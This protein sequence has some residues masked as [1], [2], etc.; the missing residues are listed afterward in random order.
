MRI[1]MVRKS[2]IVVLGLMAVILGLFWLLNAR[3]WSAR[4]LARLLRIDNQPMVIR[5]PESFVPRLPAGFKVS[6]LARGFDQPRCVA[7]APNGDVFVADSAAGKI[8]VLHLPAN[9]R[10]VSAS[11]KIFAEN[12]N[13]PFGIAFHGE[14]VYVANTNQVIRFR[15]DLK[16]SNRLSDAEPI[17]NLPGGGYNQHWTRS[18]A[19]SPDGKKLFVSLGS[20]TNISVE[21]DPRRAAILIADPDGGNMQIYAGGLRNA[22]GIAFNPESGDLWASVNE[23]DDISDDIPSDFFTHVVEGGFYWWPYAYL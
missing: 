20:K 16:S 3:G 23:R 15:Y 19:F 22:V 14:Y 18:L 7:P 12:L 9:A 2:I 8:L 21:S 10:D 1:Q 11:S 4:I 6:I 17:L 13:L 5:P